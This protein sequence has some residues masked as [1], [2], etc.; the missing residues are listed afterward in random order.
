M[1]TH[2]ARGT[3]TEGKVDIYYML[4]GSMHEAYVCRER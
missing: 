2:I 3:V 1:H 4:T